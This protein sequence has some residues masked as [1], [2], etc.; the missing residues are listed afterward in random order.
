MGREA[1]SAVPKLR[2]KISKTIEK[3][4]NPPRRI[5][6]CKVLINRWIRMISPYVSGPRFG[7]R[8]LHTVGVTGS[9]PV[10][11]TGL[12]R[13][14]GKAPLLGRGVGGDKIT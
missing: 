7:L 1:I 4:P 5:K 14:A 2:P 6:D 13:D 3:Y 12:S 11:P 10:S 8:L 9:N